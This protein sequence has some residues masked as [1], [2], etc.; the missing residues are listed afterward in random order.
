VCVC[1]CVCPALASTGSGDVN[2]ADAA[3]QAAAFIAAHSIAVLNV[4]GPRESKH[5]G[6]RDFSRSVVSILIASRQ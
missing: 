5:A 4:A 3:G 6:A 1:V 2:A